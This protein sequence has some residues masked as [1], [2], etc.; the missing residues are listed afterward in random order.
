MTLQALTRHPRHQ[1]AHLVRAYHRTYGLPLRSQTAQTT[2]APTSSQK[3]IPLTI[4]N[5]LEGKPIPIYGKAK[6]PRLALR[7]DHCEAI[8]AVIQ[9]RIGETYYNI[10]GNEEKET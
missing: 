9:G 2:T 7:K 8:W 1:A 4:L 10:S 3:L 5:A 6:R